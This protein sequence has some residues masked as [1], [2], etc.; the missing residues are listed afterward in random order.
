LH[1]AYG[2]PK[3]GSSG[4]INGGEKVDREGTWTISKGIPADPDAVI[5]CLRDDKTNQ[6][7][8]FLKLSDNLLHLLDSERRLMIGSAAWSYTLN[9]STN[10]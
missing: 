5:Y 10:R 9:R 4:F 2:L 7:I 8:C 6:T 3:Q 1:C